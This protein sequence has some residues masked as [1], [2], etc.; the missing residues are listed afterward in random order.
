[1]TNQI[2]QKT[3]DAFHLYL[4]HGNL[5]RAS[6]NTGVSRRTLQRFK[7]A[8]KEGRCDPKDYGIPAY[9]EQWLK[10][11]KGNHGG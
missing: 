7:C 2:Q 8:M 9:W 10:Q 6:E 11:M 3:I 1:M 5:K 4:T